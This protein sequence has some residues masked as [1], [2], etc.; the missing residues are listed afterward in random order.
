M[1][2]IN[3]NKIKYLNSGLMKQ[4]ALSKL[5]EAMSAIKEQLAK[6]LAQDIH[7]KNTSLRKEN[8]LLQKT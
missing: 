1:I 7:N 2:S 6:D 8:L 3:L 4:E 5:N